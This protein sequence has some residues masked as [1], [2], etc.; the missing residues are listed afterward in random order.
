MGVSERLQEKI[1]VS[2]QRLKSF[3]PK[4]G[5]YLAFSG[6]KDSCVIKAL[7]DMAGVK[8][9]AVYRV[10][11][12]DPPELVRF[13]KRFHPDVKME[14][15]RDADGKRITMWSMIEK[16]M[17]PP[18]RLARYCCAEF[19]ESGG[20]GEM[21]ITGVRWAESRNRKENQGIAT[22]S[23]KSKS[24]QKIADEDENF[25]KNNKGG[26]ILVNDNDESR[27]MVEQCYKRHKTTL[28]P[29]IDWTDDD[30]WK[31]I[32]GYEIPYCCLYDE[33]FNRLGCIG[34]PLVGKRSMERE[35]A[36][37]PKY[38]E[39]YIKAFEKML[40]RRKETG[41]DDSTGDWISAKD[42]FNWWVGYDIL[43]GQVDLFEEN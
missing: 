38:K 18:T 22:V 42:V 26:I 5:Y 39:L 29:I 37:Y 9:H 33:G 23:S 40:K 31:F 11:G 43:P 35:F 21:T 27:R 19:K 25:K 10:T 2:I 24:V 1:S 32:R 7:A 20:D 17:M 16:K 30:V 28:N 6:G 34:C 8:Y 4:E 14:F 41:K 13:I 15:P 3:E 36:R 12:I